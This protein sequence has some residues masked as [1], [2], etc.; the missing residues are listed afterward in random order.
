[1]NKL[2]LD[3]DRIQVEQFET[4]SPDG[5]GGTVVGRD[6]GSD[7]VNGSCY[8]EQSCATSPVKWCK[9]LCG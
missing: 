3:L 9:P 5:K 7:T 1:M 4:V 6:S 8:A 2:R